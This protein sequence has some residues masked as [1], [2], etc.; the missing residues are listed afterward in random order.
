MTAKKI[1]LNHDLEPFGCINTVIGELCVFSINLRDQGAL[2]NTVDKPKQEV[3]PKE[4]VKSLVKFICFP[5]ESLKE[6]KYKPDTPVINQDQINTLTEKDLESIAKI[7]VEK[8]PYLY[9]ELEIKEETRENGEI[10]KIREY[11]KVIHPKNENESNVEY[12]HRLSIL[13]D[14][15]VAEKFKDIYE[16]IAGVGKFSD[17]LTENI[18]KTLSWGDSLSKSLEAL[19]PLSGVVP[20]T[21][22]AENT[23]Q[24]K[25]NYLANHVRQEFLNS[26]GIDFAKIA[27]ESEESRLKP[28]NDLSQ[29]LDKLINS[30][31]LASEFM[32]KANE[33]QTTIASEIK[34]S[35]DSST[36]FSKRNI[37]LSIAVL[38]ISAVSLFMTGYSIYST[39]T[40][41]SEQQSFYQEKVDA[42]INEI[43]TLNNV[44]KSDQENTKDLIELLKTQIN[45]S[46]GKDIELAKMQKSYSERM[47]QLEK[48]NKEQQ[49]TIAKLT[50]QIEILS[51]KNKK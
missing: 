48:M 8:N 49:K 21:E 40:S 33:I 51:G 35:S 3:A 25:K 47:E 27:R 17:S 28:F 24:E 34:S 31:V 36:L 42:V 41:G 38:V 9:K 20:V 5:K 22:H 29:R 14:E 13:E 11:N 44:S 23:L 2:Y 46:K 45:E 30:S 12:L 43:S 39:T 18:K 32:I 4:Y 26:R 6:G 15:K 16:S 50:K 19:K 37:S 10:E 1:R 7:Y